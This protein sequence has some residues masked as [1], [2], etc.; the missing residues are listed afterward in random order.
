MVDISKYQ[1]P[2]DRLTLVYPR[3][4]S[5]IGPVQHSDELLV[6]TPPQSEEAAAYHSEED[7]PDEL[8]DE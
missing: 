8:S 2:K 6:P 5:S 1:K 4:P 7:T 3:I